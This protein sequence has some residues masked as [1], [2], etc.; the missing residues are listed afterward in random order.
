MK[1]LRENSRADFKGRNFHA[2][3]QILEEPET[4]L[5]CS[6]VYIQ[7]GLVSNLGLYL[8]YPTWACLHAEGMYGVVSTPN[9]SWGKRRGG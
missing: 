7:L 8:Q 4:L 9:T 5:R 3:G 2:A 1:L 6:H